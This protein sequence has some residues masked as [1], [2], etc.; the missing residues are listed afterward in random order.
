MNQSSSTQPTSIKIAFIA[1][2]IFAAC[3]CSAET[4]NIDWNDTQVRWHGYNQGLIL[5]KQQNKPIILILYAD[6]CPACKRHGATFSDKQVIEA[7]QD[8]MMI[9]LNVDKEA[10]LSDRYKLDGGYIPRTFAL[11][12]NG[13]IMHE[14]YRQKSHKFFIGTGVD[15]LLGL[16][17]KAQ[18]NF[19]TNTQAAHTEAPAPN[20]PKAGPR[21]EP[22]ATPTTKEK[23]FKRTWRRDMQT[24]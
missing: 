16:M 20:E 22:V 23:Y 17:V 15:D 18:I 7:T 10:S 9:R 1:L 6:W 14:I 24:D 12:P 3:N 19:R 13:K 2:L 11:Y 4:N 21:S 8:F 5:A